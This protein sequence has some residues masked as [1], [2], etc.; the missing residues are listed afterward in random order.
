MATHIQTQG[1][2]LYVCFLQLWVPQQPPVVVVRLPA[3]ACCC[4]HTMNLPGLVLHALQ[5]P[6]E[7]LRV[8]LDPSNI[9][10]IDMAY[11]N[12]APFINVAVAGGLSAVSPSET[13]SWAKRLLG[14][15]AIAGHGEGAR[16]GGGRG[17]GGGG[18]ERRGCCCCRAW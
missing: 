6:Q 10:P 14:P 11:L 4:N 1:E 7:A 9:T 8:A 15:V 17:A 12:G 18:R 3:T 13:S 5:D 2:P 16:G